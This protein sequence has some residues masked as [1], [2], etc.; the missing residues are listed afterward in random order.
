MTT[1]DTF[2]RDL[3]L[4]LR[5]EGE[6]RV[7]D[8]L[9][10]VLVRSAA[11]RQRPWWSSLE[12]WLH[13]DTVAVGR[14]LNLRPVAIIALVV[15]AL[16]L[17]A[18]AALWV[19]SQRPSTFELA[20]NGRIFVI[21]GQTLKSYSAGGGDPQVV[22]DLPATATAPS[23]SP[24]G[25]SIAYIMDPL[26]RVD[27]V[28][29]A[30]GTT[31]TIPLSGV[32][33]V[34]GPVSWSP[35]GTT[36]LFNTFDGQL[37][38]LVTAKSDGTNVGEIDTSTLSAGGHVELS[39][40]GWSP[41]G[42]RVAFVT[43]SVPDRGDGTLY[44]VRADGTDLQ[45]VGPDRVSTYSVSW[46]PDPTV[47]RLVL[48]ANV[49]TGSIVRILDLPS[50]KQTTV[51]S[52]FWPT[53]SPDGS[54]ISYWNEGTVVAGTAGA[55]SGDPG[56]VR[57]YP[58]VTG[59]CQDHPDLAGAAY[60]G[61]AAWSPDGQRLLAPDIVGGSILSVMADGTGEPIVIPV[62]AASPDEGAT[63]AWQPIRP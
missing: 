52:G 54:R 2:G 18:L 63:A 12:R 61:P 19:A 27:I 40:A 28:D 11:T 23:I 53:W 31:T 39:P 47:E 55:L 44:V 38:H 60:C 58:Q 17:A 36:V 30:N 25:R 57:P 26:Q 21:D 22:G 20:S 42:D 33:G 8:H 10:E 4:W 13:V 29:I 3:S 6:H 46:S 56:N 62:D 59:D 43:A 41:T 5:E 51:D 45:A 9:A 14:P 37:E 49:G 16:L 48:A 50:G 1:R 32:V 15:G 35:D 34:G 24:D 7:P